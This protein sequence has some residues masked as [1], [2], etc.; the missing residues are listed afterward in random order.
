M[1]DIKISIFGVVTLLIGV[2]IILFSP[3]IT[4]ILVLVL[5]VCIM[6]LNLFVRPKNLYVL[7]VPISIILIISNHLLYAKRAIGRVKFDDL[8]GNYSDFLRIREA[9]FDG[10]LA[11]ISQFRLDFGLSFIHY[12]LRDI[13]LS[14]RDLFYVY[15]W[16]Q[17]GLLLLVIYMMKIKLSKINKHGILLPL[18]VLLTPD[19]NSTQFSRQL[20]SLYIVVLLY[21]TSARLITRFALPSFLHFS[22]SGV[23]IILTLLE[24]KAFYI[25]TLIALIFLVILWRFI[26]Y[27]IPTLIT[28]YGTLQLFTAESSGVDFKKTILIMAIFSISLIHFKRHMRTILIMSTCIAFTALIQYFIPTYGL[29]V[30]QLMA[31]LFVLIAFEKSLFQE[32]TSRLIMLVSALLAVLNSFPNIW[33]SYYDAGN[34]F[35]LADYC[36]MFELW[37]L[38]ET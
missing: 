27:K 9:G 36:A 21:F 8:I 26:E 28:V 31:I 20:I 35:F 34:I 17:I 32:S 33:N 16:I 7:T 4:T 25:K 11:D 5:C 3:F 38:L 10:L 14:E 2:S 15:Q 23:V 6:F 18:I 30:I 37:C 19:F 24:L 22:S 13:S 29:R 12:L 1:A